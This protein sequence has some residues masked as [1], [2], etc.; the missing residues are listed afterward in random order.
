MSRV[1]AGAVTPVGAPSTA[2]SAAGGGGGGL[3]ATKFFPE[4]G[5]GG[6][7]SGAAAV[8]RGVVP[9]PS[10]PHYLNPPPGTPLLGAGVGVARMAA[11][12]T[13]AAQEAEYRGLCERVLGHKDHKEAFVRRTVMALL[14][15]LAAFFPGGTVDG[16]FVEPAAWFLINTLRQVRRRKVS[17]RGLAF[18]SW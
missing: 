3:S 10:S 13:V 9:P 14:P 4:G 18:V 15:E 7:G 17:G 6:G 12:M 8:G 5:G 11:A 1:L 2:G 16:D